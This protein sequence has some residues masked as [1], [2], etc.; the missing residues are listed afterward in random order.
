LP[1]PPSA[2]Y[3]LPRDAA[4]RAL[5]LTPAEFLGIEKRTGSIEAGKDGDFLLL[6]GDPLSAQSGIRE[7]YINGRPVFPG[8]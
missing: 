7:V 5:T 4:L 8:E 3:G 2:K 6:S 1:S